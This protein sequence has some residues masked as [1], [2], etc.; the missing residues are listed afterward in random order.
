M[1]SRSRSIIS[2]CLA[3]AAVT[4]PGCTEPDNTPGSVW[5][6]YTT[7]SVGDEQPFTWLFSI[8]GRNA[9]AVKSSVTGSVRI[10]SLS[11]GSHHLAVSALPPACSTGSDERDID[12]PAGDTAHIALAV[13]CERTT[14]DLRITVTTTG[15]EQDLN[16]YV[17]LLDGN[18]FA[19][20]F[21]GGPPILA[22]R[23][24]AGAHTVSLGNVASNCTATNGPTFPVTIN[25]GELTPLTITVNCV[26]VSGTLRVTTTTSGGTNADF[27]GYV[28][29]VDTLNIPVQ[30]NGVTSVQ[31]KGGAYSIT[32]TDIEP[33]CT[34]AAATKPVTIPVGGTGDVS[35]DVTCGAYPATTLGATAADPVNDT[36]PNSSK[37]PPVAFDLVS[38][39][40]GYAPGFMTVTLKFS[41]SVVGASMIGFVDFDLDEN[42]ATG[43]PSVASAFGGTSPQGVEGRAVFQLTPTPTAEFDTPTTF[44][45]IRII[46]DADSI[47]LLIPNDV[48]GD[49]GNV[50]LTAIIGS[51]DRPTDLMPNSGPAIVSHRPAG[52]GVADVRASVALPAA[53]AVRRALPSPSWKVPPAR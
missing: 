47:R 48:M 10:D 19:G 46:A 20:A 38:L 7:T 30:S 23:L 29:K 1:P 24:S 50:T 2:L 8:D 3:A 21:P 35:F 13:K 31:V 16:G 4:V 15:Q 44:R 26:A 6:D 40:T 11:P 39:S 18:P 32:L 33:N 45:A 42:P 5:V 49:E 9:K 28:V 25:K 51:N 17:V 34:A 27:N 41:A 22:N 52:A 14:G 12:I 36:L 53:A 37:T 43:S